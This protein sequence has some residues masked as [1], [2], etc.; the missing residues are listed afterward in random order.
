MNFATA[1]ADRWPYW[2]D[3][4]I[5]YIGDIRAT[6][7]ALPPDQEQ[8]LIATLVEYYANWKAAQ[9]QKGRWFA[10]VGGLGKMGLLLFGIAFLIILLFALFSPTFYQS[11]ANVDQ[12]RGMVTFFF[13]LSATG[14]IVL[15]A[16]SIFWIDSSDEVTKRFAAAKDLL[17][18]VIGVVGTIMG[19][20][21]GTAS[22]SSAN[23]AVSSVAVSP[24]TVKA[25]EKAVISAKFIGGAKPYSYSIIFGSSS[26]TA[27]QLNPL[28]IKSEKSE[29]GIIS[30]QI[31]A[32][33]VT[34]TSVLQYTIT[35][36]DKNSASAQ[37]SGGLTVEKK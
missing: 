18:I 8:T 10:L 32:P 36:T 16:M 26:L 19:F 37:S 20:Y 17:T 4:A 11:L 30:K 13:V 33:A 14:I 34:D 31:I 28:Q 6:N 21:F 35:A 7:P 5:D 1:N 23:L 12:L 2:S 3:D 9:T 25:G 29:D 22:N 27:A 15:F 24:L